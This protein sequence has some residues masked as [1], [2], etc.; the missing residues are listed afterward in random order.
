V[1]DLID[2][3]LAERYEP[4]LTSEDYC[5]YNTPAWR[6]PPCPASMPSA[7]A[8]PPSGKIDRLRKR[9]ADTAQPAFAFGAL[10]IDSLSITFG[11]SRFSV[12]GFPFFHMLQ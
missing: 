2:R 12:A 1:D 9:R 10:L 7:N 8:T 5:H 4:F 3:I 6:A 11:L